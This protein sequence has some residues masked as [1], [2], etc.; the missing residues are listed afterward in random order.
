[1]MPGA[2][3]QHGERQQYRHHDD[4]RRDHENSL[5]R[6]GRNPVF[7]GEDLDHV[8]EH[9][10]QAERPYAIG[11][12]AVL[13]ECQKPAFYPDEQRRE[14]ERHDQDAEDRHEWDKDWS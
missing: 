2:N 6:E 13:P 8:G 4:G 1:M 7:L 9:L 3:G 14:A 5:V 10:Q 12:V 11:S